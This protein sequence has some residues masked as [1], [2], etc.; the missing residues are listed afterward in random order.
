MVTCAVLTSLIVLQKKLLVIIVPNLVIVVW[1]VPN[2]AGKQVWQQPRPYATSVVKKVT[3][4]GAAQTVLSLV[5][6]KESC[7]RIVV[8]MTDGKMIM[9][10]DQLLM[11]PI[12]EKAPYWRIEGTS[13]VVNP[14]LGVVG[15]LR[16]M[17]MCHL[18]RS[19]NPMG[20]PLRHQLQRS[21]TV[22][23]NSSMVMTI[24]L[25]SL[26]DGKAK[27]IH[28]IA[29]NIHQMQE[30]IA[31]DFPTIPMFALRKVRLVCTF[32]FVVPLMTLDL[33]GTKSARKTISLKRVIPVSS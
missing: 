9:A 6:L 23:T 15:F 3:S 20:G 25:L 27:V 4:H 33:L 13:L 5:G 31:Q 30:T 32:G 17:M 24:Q 19:T 1:D 22:I 2:N 21:H 26:Q 7:Q 8:K 16:T 12:K 28:H 29:Q 10:I 18:I 11:T 14:E